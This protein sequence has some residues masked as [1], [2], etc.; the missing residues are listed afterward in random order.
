MMEITDANKN[1]N[2][3]DQFQIQLN[4]VWYDVDAKDFFDYLYQADR[5]DGHDSE[6]GIAWINHTEMNFNHQ[7]QDWDEVYRGESHSYEWW[8]EELIDDDEVLLG[9]MKTVQ[10]V[11]AS[12]A[13]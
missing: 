1:L 12:Q 3:K 4:G 5:I 10:I 8:I 9:Y 13:A 7:T 2:S 6:S 11:T